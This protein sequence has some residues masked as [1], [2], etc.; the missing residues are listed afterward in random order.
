MVGLVDGVGLV[1]EMGREQCFV[2]D[3]GRPE[4]GSIGPRAA[5][6]KRVD[7]A[8]MFNKRKA[9][10]EQ[11]TEQAAKQ[12]AVRQVLETLIAEDGTI[13]DENTERFQ[14][15]CSEQGFLSGSDV[16]AELPVDVVRTLT[17]ARAYPGHFIEIGTTLFLKPGE[18]CYAEVGAGMLKEVVQREFRGGSQGISVPLGH[19]VRY[20]TGAFRGHMVTIGTH[21]QVADSGMLTVTDKRVV[22][23][24]DRKTLEFSFDKLATLNVYSDAID[25]GVTSRQATSSFRVFEPEFVAGMIHAAVNANNS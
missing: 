8:R 24:G 23:H 14:S 4:Q 17:L 10:K 21:W 20:R 3:G 2:V 25:L 7:S 9:A 19:G 13:S 22:Y 6:L 16:N 5:L 15:Y 18:V 1:C 11:A 12:A